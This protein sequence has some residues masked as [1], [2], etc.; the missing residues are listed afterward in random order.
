MKIVVGF[1]NG[2]CG[3][4]RMK[5]SSDHKVLEF[6]ENF[7]LGDISDCSRAEC[8]VEA[9]KILSYGCPGFNDYYTQTYG[10]F[11]T[12]FFH[13][14]KNASEITVWLEQNSALQISA[15][16]ICN[17]LFMISYFP[18]DNIPIYFIT[19]NRNRVKYLPQD[20]AILHAQRKRLT[21]DDCA[22]A[23]REWERL[24]HSNKELRI[25]KDQ[26]LLEKDYSYYDEIF[27]DAVKSVGMDLNAVIL[28]LLDSEAIQQ[29]LG[30]LTWRYSLL[31]NPLIEHGNPL[32]GGGKEELR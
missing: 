32:S 5:L 25:F 21:A 30:F 27:L 28:K 3:I 18:L 8:R 2:I 4:L 22:A 16:N 29:G 24:T 7:A 26:K 23:I 17:L 19:L 10:S 31:F 1:N 12:Q 11:F 14:Y 13:N 15:P 20:V 9:R 6:P